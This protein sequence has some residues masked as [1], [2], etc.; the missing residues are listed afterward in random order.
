[1][2]RNVLI[3]VAIFLAIVTLSCGGSTKITLEK[4]DPA[5]A[6]VAA[7]ELSVTEPPI[8][9][10]IQIEQPTNTPTTEPTIAPTSTPTI[11]PTIAP[12]GFSRSNP[13]PGTEL[14]SAPNWDIQVL[15]MKRGVDAWNDI[16]AANSYNEPAPEGME[17][18]MVKIHVKCTYDDSDEHSI[19]GYDF[20]VTGDKA[21]LYTTSMASVVKPEP[22]LDATLFSGGETEGWSAYLVAQGEGNLML[23]FDESWSFDE[24]SKRYIAL[25]PGASITVPSDL[26]AF[27][28][29]ELGKSRNSPLPF[30]DRLVT[31]DWEIA[32]LEV[33][34]G[35]SAWTLVQEANSYN[36]PPSDGYEYIAVKFYVHNIGKEDDS[37]SI[38][39]YSFNITGS[40][41][42][43]HNY[44]SVV[45]PEPMLEI[46]LYPDGEYE[47]WVVF[48]SIIGETDLMLAF[49]ESWSFDSDDIRYLALDEGAS[50]EVPADL[51][52]V[53]SNNIGKERNTPALMSESVITDDWE[54]SVVE[55]IRGAEAWNMALAANQ[56]NDPPEDG[57]EYVA[58]KIYVHNINTE[59]V[60]RNI[61]DY[62]FNTT[63]SKGV[64]H[65][66]P[67]VVD[68]E[69]A[70]DITLY[71][72]GKYE[73]WLILKAGIGE[74]DLKLVF[75]PLLDFSDG[76]RYISLEP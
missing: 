75:E 60:A 8:E 27:M 54:I 35:D 73:G 11:A 52:N 15:E 33:V 22:E 57:Y 40:A 29:S 39:G 56:Y 66:V 20:D 55:V 13:F 37:K 19:S 5:T 62:D 72:D 30:K 18:L 6:T 76:K 10:T 14:V 28:P 69:P 32:I 48:E 41:N 31:D 2:K 70:L 47:G 65:D 43:L 24:N 53:A 63:G 64:L 71:P 45:D 34:R 68:P 4:V 59:D 42:I 26:N 49:E 12:I 58:V 25:N 9:P 44:R 74:T 61:N 23:I 21:I 3:V 38:D 17:Y 7:P 67:S 46:S 50:L 1:M 16:Q 36:D 51:A